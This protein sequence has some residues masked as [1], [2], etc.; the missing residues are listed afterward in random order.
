MKFQ[1]FNFR[2][3]SMYIAMH[4][5]KDEERR[6]PLYRVLPRRTARNGVRPEVSAKPGN[7]E[8]WIFPAA[9]RTEF[10]ERLIVAMATQIG[11]LTMMSSPE[12]Q[13]A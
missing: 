11:V 8:N 12:A 13:S 7:E 3:A 4:M 5:T 9:D 2:M 10:E 1:N 6:S